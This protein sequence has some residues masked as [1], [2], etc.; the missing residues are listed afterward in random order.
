MFACNHDLTEREVAVADG[1]CALC[2]ARERDEARAEREALESAY[3]HSEQRR[4]WEQDRANV[5][6][7]TVMSLRDER[8]RLCALLQKLEWVDDDESS[9]SWP[10][11]PSCRQFQ[12]NG[13]VADCAIKAALEG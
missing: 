8:D 12:Y 11:C 2:L 4:V 7:G 5:A 10:R 3:G 1:Q 6:N 9:R 13:H